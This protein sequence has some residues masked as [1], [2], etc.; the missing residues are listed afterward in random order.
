M[1][2]EGNA[3]RLWKRILEDPDDLDTRRIFADQLLEADDPLGEYIQLAIGVAEMDAGDP[4]RARTEERADEL[5]RRNVVPWTRAVA[6]LP[7]LARPRQ[8][9]TP[10]FALHRGL[11]EE[12]TVQLKTVEALAPVAAVA[13]IRRLV[14]DSSD[15]MGDAWGPTL[16]AMPEL[17]KI[18]SLEI[19]PQLEQTAIAL[20]AS[21]HLR[22]LE[23]LAIKTPA[24][25]KLAAA[26]SES[27]ACAGLV[28]LDL[29]NTEVGGAGI[30]AEGAAAIAKVPLRA[31]SLTGH[32]IGDGL[33]AIVANPHLRSLHIQDDKIGAAGATTIAKSAQLA[34]LRSLELVGCDLGKKGLPAIAGAENLAKLESLAILGL[35]GLNDK[36]LASML[37]VWALSSLKELRTAGP[38]RKAGA[39]AI[40]KSKALAG[41]T[42]V[43]LTNA[44]LKD[45]GAAA[46]ARWSPPNLT[47]LDLSANGIGPAGMGALAD[48]PLLRKVRALDLSNNKCGTEGGKALAQAPWLAHL[49]K[50]TLFYNWMGVLGVR[51]ILER[52]PEAENLSMG[53]N[54]YGT[55]PLRVASRG[56]LPRLRKASFPGDDS[57]LLDT[58]LGLEGTRRLGALHLHGGVVTSRTAGLLGQLPE[59]SELGFNFT[60]FNDDALDVL[61]ERFLGLMEFWP[62]RDT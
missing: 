48:G 39:A 3:A 56:L 2:F 60:S 9:R 1:V 33:R 41:L 44:S 42:R 54:N 8:P 19:S 62:D 57:G 49:K 45:D 35:N 32:S 50:L 36:V 15:Y 27:E 21:P 10:R 34:N 4:R 53:E 40:A 25:P 61:R 12:L 46:L 55:E 14:V 31:L 23:R 51:A 22:R 26:I 52:M 13:P 16:A 47:D 59:L 38:L 7:A 29:R 24:T 30:R 43:G 11:V 37:E 5:M 58:W 6:T 20:L 28:E 17:A 18:R